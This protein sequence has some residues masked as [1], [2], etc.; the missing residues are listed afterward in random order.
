MSQAASIP[1]PLSVCE[2]NLFLLLDRCGTARSTLDGRLRWLLDVN[3]LC[4]LIELAANLLTCWSITTPAE[5][6]K[7]A[8]ALLGVE[9]PAD[10]DEEY[11]R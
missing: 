2:L 5:A 11:S 8:A 1:D 10:E 4:E 3:D 9:E 7:R 6:W